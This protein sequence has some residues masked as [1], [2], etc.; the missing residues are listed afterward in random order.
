MIYFRGFARCMTTKWSPTR[1]KCH[2]MASRENALP[3]SASLATGGLVRQLMPSSHVVPVTP[4]C[5]SVFSGPGQRYLRQTHAYQACTVGHARSRPRA[6]SEC[7]RV[8]D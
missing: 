8:H 6:A 1:R 5:R 7:V 3:V 2:E 4:I